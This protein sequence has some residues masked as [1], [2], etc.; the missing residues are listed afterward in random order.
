MTIT[1]FSTEHITELE[2]HN[3]I[4]Y[5]SVYWIVYLVFLFHLLVFQYS[6][7]DMMLYPAIV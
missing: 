1:Q 4:S 7:S 5:Y 3:E 2:H 6:Y